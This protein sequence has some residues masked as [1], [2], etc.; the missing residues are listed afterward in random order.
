MGRG[1]QFLRRLIGK[2][3]NDNGADATVLI[4]V[5]RSLVG[6][7]GKVPK[8]VI[9]LRPGNSLM[10]SMMGLTGRLN[11]P[12]RGVVMVS[13]AGSRSAGFGPF[14]KPVNTT[15]RSFQ[16]AVAT[17]AR[18]RSAFFGKRR[19]RATTFCAVLT[20]VLF[21]GLA[22]VAR[23]R[24]VFLSTHCLTALARETETVVRRRRGGRSVPRGMLGR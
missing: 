4:E 2:T 24:R 13:P 21:K 15:T 14:C 1:R 23:V 9:I 19:R 10:S 22:G 6:V 5:T 7:S 11:I 3:A 20:G 12:S 8:K 17:L 16:K 18:G